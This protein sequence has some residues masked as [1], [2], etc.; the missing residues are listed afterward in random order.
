MKRHITEPFRI[1]TKDGL[2]FGLYMPNGNIQIFSGSFFR[3]VEVN[4]LRINVKNERQYLKNNGYI[5]DNKLIKNYT[6]TNPSLAISTLMGY[7]E[8]GNQAFFTNDNIELGSYL[9]VDIVKEY[10]SRISIY[11]EMKILVCNITW[12]EKYQGKEPVAITNWDFVKEH[13]FGYEL[14]NFYD[15]DG[16]YYGYTELRDNKINIRRIDSSCDSNQVEDVLVVWISRSPEQKLTVVGFYKNATVYS[17]KQ[18]RS[19]NEEYPWYYI[20]AKTDNSYLIPVEDR[21][22]EFPSERKNR[23][24]QSSIWYADNEELKVQIIDYIEKIDNNRPKYSKIRKFVEFDDEFGVIST[25]DIEK[26]ITVEPDYSPA[27]KAEK[28]K[29][30]KLSFK[31]SDLKA[32]KSIILSDYK[33]NLDEKH[34][35]FIAKNGKPYMEAHHLIP[36]NAQDDFDNSLDVDANIV[37]LCSNCH[38]KLHFGVDI[39]EDL[40][41]LYEAREEAL[42]KSQIHISFDR[43]LNYYL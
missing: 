24:G 16:F 11:K 39:K 21:N 1:Q 29:G 12:M 19:S 43:L 23:P 10:E 6:F 5:K 25:A 22:F 27:E 34:E 4:S 33:C 2:V 14:L 20:K 8:T 15:D 28:V 26:E 38:K 32:K 7:M 30:V 40:N 42:I 41:K 36:L 13:G 9:E 37:C 3:N 18:K 35:S 31:R 17:S